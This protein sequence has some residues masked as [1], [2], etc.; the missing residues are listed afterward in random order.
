MRD[1]ISEVIRRHSSRCDYLD[2]RIERSSSFSVSIKDGVIAHMGSGRG[3]GGGVR[4]CYKGGWG[5]ASFND[6]DDL[7]RFAG[8]AVQQ[9]RVVGTETT[10]L[11]PV[12]PVV[13]EFATEILDDPRS[14]S[15]E[16]KVALLQGYS[17]IILS[18][19]P[20][21]KNGSC[22][23]HDE[24]DERFFASS[25]GSFV[26]QKGMDLAVVASPVAQRDGLTTFG[27]VSGGSSNDYRVVLG[28]EE[29]IR[30][31][32]ALA[33]QMLDAPKVRGGVYT[34][35][36]DPKLAGVFVHEAF[37][38]TSEA[39]GCAEN[40]QLA[41]VMKLGAVFGSSILNIYDTG[42]D[43]GCRG[44][45]PYDD[46]GV[47]GQKTWLIRDGV[48]VGRLHSRETAAQ[49]GE[50]PTGNA[51][52]LSYRFEPIPRM[53]NTCIAGGTTSVEAMIGEVDEGL[54]VEGSHGG[55][56]GEDFSFSALRG[57]MIRKGRLEEYVRSVKL[58]GNLWTTMKNIDAVGNDF[59]IESGAGGC[60]KGLQFPLPVSHSAPHIRIRSVSVGGEQ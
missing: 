56:G 47:P 37:G 1:R 11:A 4:A 6:L 29:A 45:V 43:I 60:G 53:R 22:S 59:R 33:A 55:C 36:V 54:Y 17:D 5:F 15:I 35:V 9:A 31:E 20:H 12:E 10:K 26:S 23:Y 51:R 27:Y 42:L 44:F 40:P 48:L 41:A 34:V 49:L 30:R 21:I 38:H 28:H 19:S 32:C 13:A 14:H 58:S 46:E 3:V 24:A 52:A 25:E 16:E 7:D 57:R 8:L 18:S 2:V 39:D 50:A